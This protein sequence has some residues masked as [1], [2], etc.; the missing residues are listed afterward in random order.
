M[1]KKF[2]D[3]SQEFA[4]KLSTIEEIKKLNVGDK[5]LYQL[6]NEDF[7][8]EATIEKIL[9]N[10]TII[11]EGGFSCDTVGNIRKVDRVYKIKRNKK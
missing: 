1:G 4:S 6:D 3:L 11:T 9:E 8:T 5:F 10:G 7:Y 2:D